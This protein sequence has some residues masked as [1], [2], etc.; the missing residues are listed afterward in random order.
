MRS[1]SVATEERREDFPFLF[2]AK[3]KLGGT[4]W[5]AMPS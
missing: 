2:E 3:R 4:V 1:L 5:T